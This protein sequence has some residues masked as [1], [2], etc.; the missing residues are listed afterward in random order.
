MQSRNMFLILKNNST[1][2]NQKEEK[3]KK[4]RTKERV[5]AGRREGGEKAMV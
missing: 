2:N 5:K 4:G 1:L 3:R